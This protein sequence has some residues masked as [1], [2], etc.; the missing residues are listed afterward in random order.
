MS[1]TYTINA[2]LREDV[3]KGASRRL[4]RTGKIPAVIYG[5]DKPAVAL[6]LSHKDILHDAA[7]ESFYSSIMEVKVTDGDNEQVVIRDLQRH[8]FKQHVLHVDL[9]RVSATDVLRISVPLHFIGGE[10]SP[11]G[12]APGVVIQH[13]VTELEVAALPKDLPE[14]IEVDLS[15]LEPGA[16]VMLSDV[17]APEGVEFVERQAGDDE[18]IMIANAIHIREDQ[19]SGAAAAAEAEALAEAELELG[20]V[21]EGEEEGEGEGEGEE[22]PEGEESERSEPEDK[23]GD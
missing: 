14:F 4:R 19:G 17:I 15:E 3:G 11:A 20:E 9:L 13:Q 21:P 10:V 8:P 7:K 5:G 12:K 23:S 22:A 2:D 16:S 6:S 18:H 1:E